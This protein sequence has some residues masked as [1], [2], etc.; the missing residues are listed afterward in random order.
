MIDKKEDVICAKV[1]LQPGS[2]ARVR[3]WAS[4]INAHRT[5]A[6]QTLQEEGVSIESV[7]YDPTPEGPCLIYYMRSASQEQAMAVAAQS[8]HAIDAYHQAFKRE[9]WV[10]VKRL[11]L[12]LDLVQDRT[13]GAALPSPP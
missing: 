4:H 8:A 6:L 11:E 1:W 3:E 7:F 12:L 10:K 9:T 5:E 2:E 13:P